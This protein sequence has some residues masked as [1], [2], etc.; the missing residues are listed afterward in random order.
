MQNLNDDIGLGD[1]DTTDVVAPPRLNIVHADGQFEISTT[2]ETFSEVDV[3]FLGLVK[4]RIMWHPDIPSGEAPPPMCK[5]PDFQHGF[6]EMDDEVAADFRFPWEASKFTKDNLILDLE[7]QAKP[8]LKCSDCSFKEW[9]TDP[10]SDRP[11]CS[12]DWVVPLLYKATDGTWMPAIASFKRSALKNTKQYMGAFATSRMPLW[13]VVTRLSLDLN[14]RGSVRYSTP[15]FQRVDQTDQNDW[16]EYLDQFRS[17]REYLRAFPKV[18][19]D[20]DGSEADNVAEGFEAS[21]SP[22]GD[23]VPDTEGTPTVPE[24]E[25]AKAAP[26]SRPKPPPKPEPKEEVVEAET[27]DDDDDDPPF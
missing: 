19:T 17:V 13:S 27:V 12:E 24:P 18:R 16:P 26:K 10:K 23:G 8:A 9:G 22:W 14:K 6:P 15:K 2:K 4:Q 25:P 21:E 5:S 20:G 1:F 7:P 11:W 3:I